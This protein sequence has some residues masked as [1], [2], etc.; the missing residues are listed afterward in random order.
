MKPK[1][2]SHVKLNP[3]N[4]AL[5]CR[6]QHKNIENSQIDEQNIVM[7]LCPSLFTA[8]CT[9]FTFLSGR[10]FSLLGHSTPQNYIEF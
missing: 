4:I 9:P 3:T 7:P 8:T 1:L 5:S 6:E 2:S 10:I